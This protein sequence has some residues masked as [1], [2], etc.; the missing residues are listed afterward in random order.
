VLGAV[1]NVDAADVTPMARFDEDLGIDSLGLVDV[2]VAVEDRF[3]LVIPD[4]DWTRFTTVGDAITH[5]Q[6]AARLPSCAH[7]L[8]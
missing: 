7:Q 2:I 6:R 1:A 5:L 8:R 4:A 3:A